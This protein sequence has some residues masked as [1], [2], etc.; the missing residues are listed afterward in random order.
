MTLDVT[1]ADIGFPALTCS[2]V[3]PGHRQ[4]SLR[5]VV[6]VV[7][8]FPGGQPNRSYALSVS[9]G[10][11]VVAQFGAVDGG[12]EPATVRITWADASNTLVA[13]GNIATVVAPAPQLIL[14]AGYELIVTV[15]NPA[16]GDTITSA[17]AWYDYVET[18]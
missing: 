4:W 8:T 11:D 17:V 16:V 7:E 14:P 9:N 15:V 12:T 3:V 18:A 6:A 10:T 13:A 2:F 5:S 1:V